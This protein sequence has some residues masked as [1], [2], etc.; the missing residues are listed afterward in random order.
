MYFLPILPFSLV[1]YGDPEEANYFKQA[2]ELS[3]LVKGTVA[4]GPLNVPIKELEDY[5]MTDTISRASP[6]MAKC[7]IAVKKQR[8]SKY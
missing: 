7:V 3:S 4:N 5:Y 8:E 1:K 6:T 2:T